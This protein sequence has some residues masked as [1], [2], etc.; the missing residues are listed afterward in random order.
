MLMPGDERRGVLTRD[1]FRDLLREGAIK[2]HVP[3]DYQAEIEDRSKADGLA[4]GIA[5]LQTTWFI[6][7]CIS[8]KVQGLITTEIELITVALNGISY[9]LWWDK[10]LNIKC[11]VPVTLLDDEDRKP[12]VIHPFEPRSKFTLLAVPL[13]VAA[14]ETANVPHSI[15]K[16]WPQIFSSI[17]SWAHILRLWDSLG[18]LMGYMARGVV[19]LPHTCAL[20]VK[21]ALVG[22]PM[23]LLMVVLGLFSRMWDLHNCYGV[24]GGAIRVPTFYAPPIDHYEIFWVDVTSVVVATLFGSIHCAG[25]NFSFP[26]HAELIIWRVSSL[27]IVIVPCT[28]FLPPLVIRIKRPVEVDTMLYGLGIVIYVLA[29]LILLVEALTSLRHLPPG[30]YTVVEWTAL[31]LHM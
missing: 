14:H 28:F 15:P 23:L 3:L 5:V 21:Q 10:P 20:L 30:A 26:S 22:I 9:F 18:R 8:R 4:K 12:V 7:Q 17:F 6:A 29:R 31:L 16:K 19:T 27:I 25:W 1:M 13:V 2:G 11:C 24:N